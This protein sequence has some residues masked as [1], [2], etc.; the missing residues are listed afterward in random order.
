MTDN[1]PSTVHSIGFSFAEMQKL[2]ESVAKSG[3]FGIKNAD[4]ALT[5]MF[6]SQ[7]E[8]RHPA[9]AARDYDIIGTR[10]SKKAEA[11]QR[12]FLAA[13]GQIKWVKLSDTEAEAIFSHPQGGQVTIA[14][15]MQRVR[16]AGISNPMYNKYPRNMLRAR[17]VSEGVRTVFPA[18]TSGMY[19]PEEVHD[20]KPEPIDITP[21]HDSITGEIIPDEPRTLA[22]L[23]EQGRA[24]AELGKEELEHW[25]MSLDRPEKKAIKPYLDEVLKQIAIVADN[26]A[27]DHSDREPETFPGASEETLHEQAPSRPPRQ[28]PPADEAA[29]GDAVSP[30]A[31]VFGLPPLNDDEA[32]CQTIINEART[33]TVPTAFTELQAQLG[34]RRT[35]RGRRAHQLPQDVYWSLLSQVSEIE[36]AFAERAA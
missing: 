35:T 11:M 12:D 1:L 34:D 13:G 24:H 30:Q 16:K 17:V 32:F 7:A 28:E 10:P 19:V 21:P 31:D 4:Q 8:G 26:R 6:V 2:A 3:L 33:F 29:P 5:L 9:L 18:A 20:F 22:I 14:W 25:F 36:T 23:E 27:L 15:D